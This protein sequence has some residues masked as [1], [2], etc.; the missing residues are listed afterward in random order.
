MTAVQGRLTAAPDAPERGIAELLAWLWRLGPVRDE[1]APGTVAIAG[2]EAA[3]ELR[4]AVRAGGLAGAV[5]LAPGARPEAP[6]LP[7]RTVA[8][9]AARFRGVG[10][11]SGEH[12][13]LGG[14]T[15]AVSSSLGTHAVREDRVLVAGASPQ[16]WGDLTQ[17]WLLPALADFLPS[18]L[19]RPLV[20]LPPVGCLRLD[21]APGTAELQLL[22]H[23]K[24]DGRE[25]ARIRAMLDAVERSGSRLVIAVVA[26]ALRDEAIVPIEEV[27]P[28]SIALLAE[29]V[30]RGVLEPACHGLLHLDPAE[31]AAG[32][33][34]AREFLRLDR[35]QAGRHLDEALAW[36]S[37]RLG[38]AR[39][40]IAPAWGY[41]DGALEAAAER[42]LVTW[43]PPQ[44]GPL[45]AGHLLHETLH[46]G[47]PGL[48][49]LDY[50]PLARIAAAGLPPTVV[51]HGRLL[52][53][54]MERL[55]EA[56]DVASL[57][58]L[59]RRRDLER[60]AALPGVRWVG[61]EELAARLRAHGEV[62]V[63]G[64]RVPPGADAILIDGGP[65][66][67]RTAP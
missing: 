60:V 14:G 6:G 67:P 29:G 31:H 45:L 63:D 56:R 50:A 64:D 22:G 41:S 17:W 5:I 1:P 35:E 66:P 34:A 20:A 57:A 21:D 42:G 53:G 36:M 23:A 49:R 37:E 61:A 13:L 15:A 54:R 7:A 58:R 39:S 8:S 47:L 10:R 26:R 32:R 9:G 48:T 52:D 16:R 51:F 18:V 30:E 59:L 19:G 65:G 2:P 44:A 3:A 43:M 40:F 24:P 25:R 4:A 33:V 46:D 38:P 62:D 28:Q 12:T 55:R 11:V 27:W